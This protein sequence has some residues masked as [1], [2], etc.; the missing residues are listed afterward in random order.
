[1]N[2]LPMASHGVAPGWYPLC[3]EK[4]VRGRPRRYVLGGLPLV[5]TRIEG[6]CVVLLDR[7]PHRNVPLSQGRVLGHALECPY[8]GWRFDRDG[9]CTLIPGRGEAPKPSHAAVSYPTRTHGGM[10]FVGIDVSGG[11][12]PFS[13]SEQRDRA[14][15]RFVRR[16]ILA[17][18][19]LLVVENALDVPHTGVLHRGL[20][21]TATR[22]A[23]QVICR[24]YSSWIEAEYVGESAPSGLLGRLLGGGRDGEATVVHFDRFFL[25]GVLQVE[26]RLG[27]GAHLVIVGYVKQVDE[28][29][30]E[31]FAHV[32]IKTPLWR[33]VERALLLIIEPVAWLV[34]RQDVR[35][36]KAQADNMRRF[37][38]TR[39]M[40]TE[41]DVL[42]AGLARLFKEAQ[43]SSPANYPVARP[44]T[45]EPREVTE[46]TMKI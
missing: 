42:Y 2:H 24:R 15:V 32:S 22:R 9:R 14:Y 33:W 37:G 45:E 46:I 30:T 44:Q 20:F 17:A 8:H 19:P 23:V 3:L 18:T 26:Y 7:C 10:L 38:E 25:P 36:L 27:Q 13:T 43:T 21:R 31:L 40:S 12:E 34:V 39:F 28:D 35:M 29:R 41:L 4:E 1:M 11:S 6:S 5:A 16:V